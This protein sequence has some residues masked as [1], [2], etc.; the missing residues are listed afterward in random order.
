MRDNYAAQ[1]ISVHKNSR[2]KLCYTCV[3]KLTRC[4]TRAIGAGG[5]NIGFVTV[6]SA[7]QHS[8]RFAAQ[9]N[10]SR[11]HIRMFNDSLVTAARGWVHYE[12]CPAR[13]LALLLLAVAL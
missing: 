12:K 4:R 11:G 13:A 5:Y 9:A 1:I 8:L 7:D 3:I 2:K 10:L 6:R